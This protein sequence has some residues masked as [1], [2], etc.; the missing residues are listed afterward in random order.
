MPEDERGPESEAETPTPWQ[1]RA[2]WVTRLGALAAI[3]VLALVLFAYRDT[4]LGTAPPQEGGPADEPSV[5][6]P[7]AAVPESPPE[8]PPSAPESEPEERTEEVTEPE[9][10][11]APL[12][13]IETPQVQPNGSTA[14]APPPAD[15]DVSEPEP[16]PAE[17]EEAAEPEPVETEPA[18]DDDAVDWSA[19]EITGPVPRANILVSLKHRGL[20]LRS[21]AAIVRAYRDVA[22]AEEPGGKARRGDDRSPV[23]RYRVCARERDAAGRPVLAV[24]YPSTEDAQ[25]ALDA[26]RI[27]RETFQAIRAAHQASTCPPWDTPLGG[28][29]L[30]TDGRE[31]G[32]TTRGGVALRAD[33]MEELW[34]AVRV[35]TPI[36]FLDR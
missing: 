25:Q 35:G 1:G 22:V 8:E 27:D 10:E 15:V 14:V 18:P 5:A 13:T 3:T 7:R 2:R 36:L 34:T 24:S 31:E 4:L 23:G 33:E 12:P 16:E 32:R 20:V 9:D 11:L 6:G 30:I 28:G 21:H 19:R 26:G 29:I 17:P